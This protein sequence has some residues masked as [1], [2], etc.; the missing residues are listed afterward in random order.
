MLFVLRAH[1][2]AQRLGGH[3]V[4]PN[5]QALCPPNLRAQSP[6]S[7]KAPFLFKSMHWDHEPGARSIAPPGRWDGI[8]KSRIG[9]M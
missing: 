1:V 8:P 3:R 5:L 7:W 6:G 9:P 4:P 2:S